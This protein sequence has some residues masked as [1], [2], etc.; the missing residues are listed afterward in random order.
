MREFF[1]FG[2][3]Q[4]EAEG[5]MSW[6]HLTFVSLLML[7]MVALAMHLGKQYRHRSMRE[8]NKVLIVSAILID[9]VELFKIVMIC[10]RG[11]D[12]MGWLY[13]LPLF[14]CSVQLIAMPL[15]A[16]TK[17][18]LRE[19]SLDFVLIFGLL[20]ALLGT[21][22][23]GQ[24]YGCYPV[25]SFDNVVSGVTHA[26][27]GFA[28]LY[29]LV[30]NMASMQRRNIGITF[31]ILFGFCGAAYIANLLLDYNYMFLMAGDG[32]PYDILFNL[33]DGSEVLYP[34]G[35]VFLFVVYISIFYA[36][37]FYKNKVSASSSVH[38]H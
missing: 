20:G 17:G 29:I 30:S 14:L 27:A 4:R 35:V 33:V 31:G 26:L 11:N 13:E 34:I 6:Q 5:F 8:K 7:V 38:V 19:A 12:P 18:R 28:S 24:N 3:Y 32:T 21:Y 9:A 10:I 15:A 1:G 25:L 23:A 37:Y 22:G 16:F 2:G 36:V